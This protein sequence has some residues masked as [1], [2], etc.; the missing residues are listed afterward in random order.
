MPD[1]AGISGKAVADVAGMSGRD[2]ADIAKVNGVDKAASSASIVTD[3]RVLDWRPA[4]ISGTQVTDQSGNG[5]HGT[6]TNG[7]TVTTT[8]SG[9]TA[10]FT[11]GVNEYITVSINDSD[12]SSVDYP[13][14]YE[15]WLYTKGNLSGIALSQVMHN[16]PSNSSNID[17]HRFFLDKRSG[18]NRIA[19][20]KYTTSGGK[21]VWVTNPGF[22]LVD[23]TWYHVVTTFEVNASNQNVVTQ[24]INGTLNASATST[25]STSLRAVPWSEGN[26]TTNFTIGAIIRNTN[27]YYHG[28]VGEVRMYSDLLSTSEIQGNFDAT[29]SNYGY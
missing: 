15:T 7:A 10:F 27:S 1:I 29:K 2:F 11:D 24:Y 23:Q 4:N 19:S 20:Q 9:E 6:M 3:S 5:Y 28:Y 25:Y 12:L 26:T 17:W 16:D 13:L 22:T 8:P 21:Y 14:T 18:Q